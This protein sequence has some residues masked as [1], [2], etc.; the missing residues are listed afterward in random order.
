MEGGDRGEGEGP[1]DQRKQKEDTTKG[2]KSD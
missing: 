2:T 1:R